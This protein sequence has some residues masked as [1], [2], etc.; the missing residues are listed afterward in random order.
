MSMYFVYRSH[1]DIPSG[2]HVKWFEDASVLDWFRNHWQGIADGKAAHQ[3][4]EKL[5]G[6]SV[7]GFGTLF[8]AIAEHSLDAPKSAARLREL[9]EEH[10]YVEGEILFKP[11]LIQVLT[12]DDELEMAYYFFDDQFL[13]KHGGKAAFLLNEGWK[14]PGGHGN[15]G[16]RSAVST[17]KLMPKGAG[18]GTTYLAFLA[19]YDSGNLSDLDVE[20]G[21]RLEGVRVPDLA[22]YLA[23]SE[24][25]GD[26]PFELRLL[27]SQLLMDPQQA[28]REE[29]PFLQT[30]R[31]DPADD[32]NWL[33]YSDWLEERGGRRAGQ[34]V[35]ARGLT[36]ASRYPVAPLCN[37]TDLRGFGQGD[38]ATAQQEL[39][40]LMKGFQGRQDQDPTRSL[41]QVE[42]HVAQMCLHTDKWGKR[43]LYHRWIFFDDLWA[44]AHPDLANGI[45]RYARRWDVLS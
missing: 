40:D 29:K 12:N 33:V 36:A 17:T 2:N 44:A 32:S 30:I 25:D 19:Y 4:V 14:L 23:R 20:G 21:S 26:W 37:T 6:C 5:L 7:Y 24:P 39:H 38:I 34:E 28:S 10:L 9:L 22:R 43:D 45:L 16:Y 18:Q 41:L 27:R 15:E 11:H 8:G 3:H 42:E 35:L 31:A 13:A 1:Y